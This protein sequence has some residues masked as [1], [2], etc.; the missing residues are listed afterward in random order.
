MWVGGEI[1][2]QLDAEEHEGKEDIGINGR[3]IFKLILNDRM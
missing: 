2:S 3:I 1:H